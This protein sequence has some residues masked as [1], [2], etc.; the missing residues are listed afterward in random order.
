MKNGYYHTWKLTKITIILR[1]WLITEQSFGKPWE[2][3][4]F[5]VSVGPCENICNDVEKI[6][7]YG[8]CI[9]RFLLFYTST[10]LHHFHWNKSKGYQFAWNVCLGIMHKKQIFPQEAPTRIMVYMQEITYLRNFQW[11]DFAA[12]K[13]QHQNLTKFNTSKFIQWRQQND[14]QCQ[15]VIKCVGMKV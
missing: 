6:L 2:F 1:T 4:I 13:K 5:L 9:G 14:E 3:V 12:V 15:E 7:I 8:C 11:Y 10:S